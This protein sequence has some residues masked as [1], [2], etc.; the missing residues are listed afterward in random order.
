MVAPAE[1][2]YRGNGIIPRG[3]DSGR[4]LFFIAAIVLRAV[5]L[6]VFETAEPYDN[7]FQKKK[8]EG[9]QNM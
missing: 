7:Y 3:F 8:E 2:A 4:T 6:K 9:T 5:I 1:Y